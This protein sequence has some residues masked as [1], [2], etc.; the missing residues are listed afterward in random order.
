MKDLLI[1]LET[2]DAATLKLLTDPAK[3]SSAEKL[4]FFFWAHTPEVETET[5]PLLV[6]DALREELPRAAEDRI[7]AVAAIVVSV[8]Q[9]L[10]K[11]SVGGKTNTAINKRD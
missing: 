10:I 3:E 5:C 6:D 1:D 11:R 9:L 4:T 8:N 7:I 2:G